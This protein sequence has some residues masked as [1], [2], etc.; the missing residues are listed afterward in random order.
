M[1]KASKKIIKKFRICVIGASYVGKTSLINRFVSNNFSSYYEPTV[2]CQIY[3]RAY[4][5]NEDEPDLD[6]EF[7]DIELWDMFP[8]DHPLMNED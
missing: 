6:P 3:R 8:H 2:E 1:L 5:I 7:F 4:N